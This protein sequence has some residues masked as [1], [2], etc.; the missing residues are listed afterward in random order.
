MEYN[1]YNNDLN[2]KNTTTS[3]SRSIYN[4]VV[5]S[6]ND[7]EDGDR[8]KVRII[9]IDN[10]ISDEDLPYSNPL[11]PRFLHIT[12]KVGEVV[13]VILED[14]KYPQRVR[15]WIG[16]VISQSHKIEYDNYYT[17]LSTSKVGYFSP[18]KPVSTY[19][20]ANGVLP[21]INDI[22]IIGRINTDI[23]LSENVVRI[24]AG[25][26]ENGNMFQLNLKNPAE[27]SLNYDKNI[28]NTYNSNSIIMGDKIAFITH[29]GNPQYK[30]ALLTPED[31]DNIFQTGHPIARGDY[32]LTSLNVM[33]NAIL[34]HLHGY[35]GLTPDDNNV[36]NEL[37]KIDFEKILQKNIV[38]N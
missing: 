35:S 21:N 38:I 7:P 23:I 10:K 13:R 22:A 14:I 24:R 20:D 31:R 26:H 12:P 18:D 36:I 15:Y 33:R 34:E 8:L 1:V 3:S 11:L 9:G 6:N 37:K 4:G 32:L 30:T 5:V 17:A 29:S 16:S 2:G 28:D 25:K 19:P 27:I